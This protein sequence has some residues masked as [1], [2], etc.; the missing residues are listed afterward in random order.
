VRAAKELSTS[1]Y[2][3][4]PTDHLPFVAFPE[5][6]AKYIPCKDV[7]DY[8]EDYQRTLGLH[9]LTLAHISDASYDASSSTWTL[10]ISLSGKATVTV[11]ARH[12]IG[13]TGI[14]TT[15]GALPFTPSIPG[16][17]R[18]HDLVFSLLMLT[19]CSA[20][21]SVPSFIQANTGSPPA[22]APRKSS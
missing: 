21:F 5:G 17:V 2:P 15:G 3:D 19:L 12:L 20:P 6:C 4:I 9:V 8:L 1:Y 7:A 16:K 22:L 13:A 11:T 18:N 10:S 14:G